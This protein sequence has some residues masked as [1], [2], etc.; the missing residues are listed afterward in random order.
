[1][2]SPVKNVLHKCAVADSSALRVLKNS[3]RNDRV[4]LRSGG[5]WVL[6]PACGR[7]I[8]AFL[9]K[10]RASA[11]SRIGAPRVHSNPA[12]HTEAVRR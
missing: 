8:V 3:N 6:Y 11:S 1:M 2:L 9:L 10:M 4:W 12:A 7:G 5:R